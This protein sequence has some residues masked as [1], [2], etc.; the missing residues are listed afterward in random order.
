MSPRAL[1][2]S[3]STGRLHSSSAWSRLFFH[4]WLKQSKIQHLFQEVEQA[5]PE[6]VARLVE[7][8]LF[9]WRTWQPTLDLIS[10]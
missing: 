6:N 7:H 4:S 9:E 10:M 5:A 8:R 3:A 2:R 1:F